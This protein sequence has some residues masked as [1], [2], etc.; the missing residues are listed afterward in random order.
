MIDPS[1]TIVNNLL[2]IQALI[3]T[4]YLDKDIKR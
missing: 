2:T 1:M 3:N 4:E